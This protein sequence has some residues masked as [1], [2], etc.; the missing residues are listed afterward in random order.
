[1]RDQVFPTVRRAIATQRLVQPGEGVVVAVSGGID[2][3][4]L[5][6]CLLRLTAE[7]RLTLSVAHFDHRLR[8]TSGR[9]ALF[10]QDLAASWGLPVTMASWVWEG[11]R[12]RSLQAEARRARY[13]F[14]YRVASSV[15]AKKIAVGHHRD[16][17]AETVLLHLL[18]GSGLRGL[19]GMLAAREGHLIR[20]LLR[21]GRQEIEVYAKVHRLSF[22]D[23]PSNRDLK[24]LRSRIRWQ[25]LP[26]LQREYNPSIVK[27]LARTAAVVAEDEGYLDDVAAEAFA[28]LVDFR[29]DRTCMNLQSLQGLASPVRRRILER[30]VQRVAPGAYLTSAHIEAVERLAHSGGSP[31]VTL[32]GGQWAWR[33]GDM[34]YVGRRGRERRSPVHQELG[35]PGETVMAESGLRVK[36]TLLPRT[37][38]DLQKANPD[39][40]Y[41]DWEQVRPPLQVRHWRPGDRYRPWGLR[42]SKKLQD[43]FVDAKIPRE[44]REKVPIVTDQNGIL[45]VAG[46]RIDERGAIK[47][48]TERILVLSLYRE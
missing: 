25:L 30:L 10:V 35:V 23:D 29:D 9:D 44:D 13:R 14:L 39:Q 38:V 16:D 45:W 34:L 31:A 21:V 24:Y 37:E 19:K 3:V 32:P 8:E 11:R 2:S 46:F 41:I 12:D 1:M 4:V 43:L 33:T 17:Q 40:A 27:T 48:A 18:R 22:L 28:R 47:G 15:G 20:P 6:H 5:L 26:I 7:F 42:G 36:A